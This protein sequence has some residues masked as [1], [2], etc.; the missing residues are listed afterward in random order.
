MINI[1]DKRARFFDVCETVSINIDIITI[2]ISV[3][4]M[5]RSDHEL[6]L[7]KFFQRAARMSFTNINN[8]SFEII[9]H[10]LNK[11]KRMSFLKMFAEYVSNE[12]EKFVF[13]IKF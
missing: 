1:I 5:K 11:K 8:K 7:K 12:K 3:F 2:S 6:L 4:V 10:F 9:L 13:A